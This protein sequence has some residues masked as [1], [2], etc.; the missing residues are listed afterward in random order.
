MSH[1]KFTHIRILALV[2]SGLLFHL[3]SHAAETESEG[4]R[5]LTGVVVEVNNGDTFLLR[6]DDN[7]EITIGVWGIDS[8]EI[9][10]KIGKSARK[11]SAKLINGERVTITVLA[12]ASDGKNLARVI[13]DGNR[14]LAEELLKQGYA[15]W[16]TGLAPD[17]A[18]YA[19]AQEK[20]QD[21]R[22]GLWKS[23]LP[24]KGL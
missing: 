19:A 20:A 6:T 4:G 3:S 8:P 10:N 18:A 1:L 14:D 22:R 13:F 9:N 17:E 11:Y 21:D 16:V 5:T 12:R 2:L 15:V 24:K 7:R 23:W